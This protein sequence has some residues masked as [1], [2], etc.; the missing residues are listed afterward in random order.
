MADLSAKHLKDPVVL[1]ATGFGSGLVP[2]APGTAGTVIAIPLYLLMQSLSL[3]AYLLITA[4]L[5][6]MGILVCSYT[7]NK[8]GVHDHPAIVIDEIVGFLVTMIAAPAGWL[9][10]V[11]GFILF[12]IFDAAKPWPIS[13]FDRAVPGGFGIMLDD[14]IAAAFSLAI[15][16]G[17]SYL[18]V[19]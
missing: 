11:I 8:L 12:R 7:A 18:Q 16:Q 13:W 15:I 14:V 6:I 17:L 10:L 1:I 4:V 19:I 2:R 9:W 3:P 5:F